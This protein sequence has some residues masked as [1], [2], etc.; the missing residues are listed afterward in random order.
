MLRCHRAA[1]SLGR[2]PSAVTPWQL[3]NP[4]SPAAVSWLSL[5]VCP[6]TAPR[7]LRWLGW[8]GGELRS[9]PSV[10]GGRCSG[11]LYLVPA[12]AA[13]DST[14]EYLTTSGNA[15]ASSTSRRGLLCRAAEYIHEPRSIS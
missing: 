5:C 1:S 9:V 15:E 3:A 10:H 4:T 13:G 2:L 6:V 8:G 7:C 12:L 11:V 14:T